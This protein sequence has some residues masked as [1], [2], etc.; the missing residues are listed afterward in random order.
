MK[1][2][3]KY[4]QIRFIGFTDEWEQHKFSEFTFAMGEKNKKGLPLEPY[5]I[6]NDRGFIPQIEAHEEFGYMKD[7]DQTMYIIVKPDMFVYNPA[8]IN[9]GSLGYY[10][11]TENVIVSSLYEVF[12]TNEDV[13]D[14][15]LKHW[16]KTIKFQNWIKKLQE[17]SVRLYFYFDK[18]CEC[19]MA[20]PLLPEQ[21]KIGLFLDKLDNLITLYQR[22]LDQLTV[23][24]KAMLGKMFPQEGERV[25]EVRFAGF[26]DDWEQRKL[27]NLVDRISVSSSDDTLP[28]IEYEDIVAGQGILNKDVYQKDSDKSGIEFAPGDILFGKLRPYLKNWLLADF[29]G[30]AVGDFWILRPNQTC[31]DWIYTLIQTEAFQ[32][33]A[34]QSAGSKMPRSD[35]NIVSNTEFYTPSIEEQ[36]KIG[37]FFQSLDNLI[38]LHQHKL[39]VLQQAKQSLL[40]KMFI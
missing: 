19:R 36:Q 12:K 23:F 33:V 32:I 4:P 6:T 30:V 35:W 34:N 37:D 13:N 22:K 5:A 14:N 11:G 18:L 38:T 10:S 17:G 25:P 9:V 40:Q 31:S 28:R 21:T 26:T 2:Q 27:V 20:I 7:V 16:F 3:Q 15:F 29:K 8:R 24:K 39:T 1:I